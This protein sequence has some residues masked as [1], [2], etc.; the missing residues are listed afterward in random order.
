MWLKMYYPSKK[1][2]LNLSGAFWEIFPSLAT[3]LLLHTVE[4]DIMSTNNQY[5]ARVRLSAT[6][7]NLTQ[8]F[9]QLE[10]QTQHILS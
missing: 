2:I 8:I 4:A 3:K 7:C 9:L 6:G 1:G 10:L 5:T